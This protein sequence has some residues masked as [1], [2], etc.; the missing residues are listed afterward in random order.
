MKEAI[1]LLGGNL[2][3]RELSFENARKLIEQKAGAILKTSALYESEPWGFEDKNLF[4][5][6]AILITTQLSPQHL[7]DTLLEIEKILG[8]IRSGKLSSRV[9][10]IDILF[11]GNEVIN[12]ENLKVPHP[13]IKERLFTLLPLSELCLNTLLP[14]LNIT[15]EEL[16]SLCQD[17]SA[18]RIYSSL[19]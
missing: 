3:N 8:R 7:L 1:V 12:T 17:K 6:Q 13:R 15:A 11:Y 5:N 9:I 4:L 19:K 16:I 18:I 14:V 10:D 2:G